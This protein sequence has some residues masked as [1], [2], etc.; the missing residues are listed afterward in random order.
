MKQLLITRRW[1]DIRGNDGGGNDTGRIVRV[2][3]PPRQEDL[4][5]GEAH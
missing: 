1:Q 2:C 4:Q 5:A 3:Y